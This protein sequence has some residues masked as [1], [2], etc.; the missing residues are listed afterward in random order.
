MRKLATATL[1]ALTA[2][3]AATVGMAS[4]QA[5]V[6]NQDGTYTVTADELRTAFGPQVDLNAVTFSAKGGNTVYLVRCTKTVG[7]KSNVVA[8]TFKRQARTTWTVDDTLIRVGDVVTGVT[9]T[10]TAVKAS[11]V[12][13][14]KGHF[15]MQG[16][17]TEY[18][19]TSLHLIARYDGTSIVLGS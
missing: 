7:K 14:P 16:T 13:C 15:V 4:A 9:L 8:H 6:V 3:A 10:P 11:P 19:V 18:R 5:L 17:P 1:A 12:S 2:T